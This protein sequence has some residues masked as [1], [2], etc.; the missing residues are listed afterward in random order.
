[1]KKILVVD[2]HPI[3]LKGIVSMLA[4]NGYSVLTATSREQEATLFGHVSDISLMVCDLSLPTTTDGIRLI[5]HVRSILPH[6][7]VIV[8]TMHDELWNIRTI[9]DIGAEGIVLKGENPNELLLAIRDVLDGNTHISPKFKKMSNEVM[10]S[11]GIL[12]KKEIEIIKEISSGCKS[13]EIAEKMCISE[14]TIEFHRRSILHKLG[15]KTIAEATKRAIEMGIL[16]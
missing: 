15:S 4:D 5:E 7:P 11:T 2:D 14:K 13:R 12:S 8:F 16:A 10:A 9:M 1:M 3:V 6:V